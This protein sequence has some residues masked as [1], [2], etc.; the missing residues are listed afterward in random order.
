M[1]NARRRL[2]NTSM[3]MWEMKGMTGVIE[4]EGMIG[5]VSPE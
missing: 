1:G 3:G 2:L 5:N 4:E